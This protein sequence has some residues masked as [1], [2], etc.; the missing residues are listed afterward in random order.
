M[1]IYN[2]FLL[3][4]ESNELKRVLQSLSLGKVKILNKSSKIQQILEDDIFSV[5]TDFKQKLFRIKINSIQLAETVYFF[6]T[7]NH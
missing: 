5:N 2:F 6:K 7:I 4:L 1:E 3:K